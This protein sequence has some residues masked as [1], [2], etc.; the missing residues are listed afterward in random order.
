MSHIGDRLKLKTGN[1]VF[2]ALVFTYTAVAY[3]AFCYSTPHPQLGYLEDLIT[4][5]SD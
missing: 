3:T 1:L 2:E 4:Q 5:S